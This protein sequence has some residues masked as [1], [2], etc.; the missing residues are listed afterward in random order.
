MGYENSDLDDEDED[1][2]GFSVSFD[3]SDEYSLEERGDEERK[4]E[5]VAWSAIL[6]V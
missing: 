4:E 2:L 5:V 1:D 6:C 3:E